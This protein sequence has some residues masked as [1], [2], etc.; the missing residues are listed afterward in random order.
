MEDWHEMLLAEPESPDE[1][2]DE[3]DEDEE[4]EDEEEEEEGKHDALVSSNTAAPGSFLPYWP[5]G[6][7]DKGFRY[8]VLSFSRPSK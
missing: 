1:E 6:S 8:C 7:C 3:E 2:E 5:S 4:E